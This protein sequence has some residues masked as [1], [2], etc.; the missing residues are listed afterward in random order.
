MEQRKFYLDIIGKGA[1]ILASLMASLHLLFYLTGWVYAASSEIFY[2]IFSFL[3]FFISF[4]SVIILVIRRVGA[5]RGTV[6]QHI[7][8]CVVVALFAAFF[9]AG[10]NYYLNTTVDPELGKRINERKRD[11]ILSVAAELQDDMR[12]K[13][14]LL[15]R[16]KL[17][18]KEIQNTAPIQFSA[19]WQTITSQFLIFALL[20]GTSLGFILNT[21]YNPKPKIST[22][23]P[24]ASNEE[25]QPDVTLTKD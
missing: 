25:L 9:Y 2:L 10:Y 15:E 8:H 19:V 14:D 21:V 4:G 7:A 11:Y 6:L 13:T 3:F 24:A 12:L 5:G 17:F 23:N 1:L 18:D 22:P 20:Y 16:A